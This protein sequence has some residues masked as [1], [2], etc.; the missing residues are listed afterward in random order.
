MIQIITCICHYNIHI[1]LWIA[2]IVTSVVPYV[3]LVL[4]AAPNDVGG[5]NNV[6]FNYCLYSHANPDWSILVLLIVD[7][8]CV[9]SP[10]M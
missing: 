9:P 5:A 6:I 8:T 4:P 7:V 10:A 3:L 1:P 2:S